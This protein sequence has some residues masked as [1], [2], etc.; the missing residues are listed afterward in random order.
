LVRRGLRIVVNMVHVFFQTI[1]LVLSATSF[2]LSLSLHEDQ[3]GRL[4]NR[5]E[6]L[7]VAVD[8]RQKLTHNRTTALFNKVAAT[9]TR[10]FDR[11]LGSRIISVQFLGVSSSFAFAGLFLAAGML[12]TFLLHRLR[13]LPSW[14]PTVPATM[15][16]GLLLLSGFC[17]ILGLFLFV[18]AALPAIWP[19]RFTRI[20]SVVP[21]LIFAVGLVKMMHLH[22]PVQHQLGMFAGLFVGLLS[23]MGLLIAVR[24]SIIWLSRAVVPLR[25]G[26]II[27]AHVVTVATIVW[28]PVEIA[29]RLAAKYGWKTIPEFLI[30]IGAFNIFTAIAA[31]T[32]ILTLLAVLLHRVFWPVTERVF[33]QIARYKV[34]RNHKAM[35]SIGA[36][37]LIGA[38][39]SIRGFVLGVFAWLLV[40]FSGEASPP[41]SAP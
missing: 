16:A 25:I 27:L 6:A 5:V 13:S 39:P 41:R 23:D 19:C 3:E 2:Y 18:I 33:Y 29:G 21:G 26:M 11:I 20:L 12:F 32:F 10:A 31:C 4:Q 35:A 15:D 17:L 9:V 37:C 28:V 14:P 7:W 40:F 8:D 30:A 24:Q 38:F 1:L 36:A 22:L 34:V